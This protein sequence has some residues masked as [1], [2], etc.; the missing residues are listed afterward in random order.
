M[1]LPSSLLMM[2]MIQ[3]QQTPRPTSTG[4]SGTK[5]SSGANPIRTSSNVAL[6]NRL[7]GVGALVSLIGI[8]VSV[9]IF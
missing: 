9:S 2:F 6:A 8:V 3:T 7:P 4:S 1:S 5:T